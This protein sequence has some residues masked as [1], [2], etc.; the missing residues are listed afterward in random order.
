MAMAMPYLSDDD[1]DLRRGAG[2]SGRDVL[3]AWVVVVLLA[4]GAVVSF[5][6]DHMVTISPDPVATYDATLRQVD[7]GRELHDTGE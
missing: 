1:D 4:I 2:G 7:E 5:A 6:L 3:S